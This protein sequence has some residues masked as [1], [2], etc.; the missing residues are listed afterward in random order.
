MN[1]KQDLRLDDL[2]P[3]ERLEALCRECGAHKYYSAEA[4][5][6]RPE[7][8]HAHLDEVEAALRCHR[9]RCGGRVRVFRADPGDTEAFVGGLA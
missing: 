8:E 7:F 5:L 2:P 4:L 1:W 3:E 9:R 6:E